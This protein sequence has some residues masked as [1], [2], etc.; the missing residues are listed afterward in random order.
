MKKARST[1]FI[2]WALI[3][4]NDLL[5]YFT[6]KPEFKLLQLSDVTWSTDDM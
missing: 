4:P 6:N 5:H 1:F 3:C 2:Y